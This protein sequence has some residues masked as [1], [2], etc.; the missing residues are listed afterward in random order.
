M[1]DLTGENELDLEAL[2]AKL[3]RMSDRDLLR[4]GRAARYMCSAF[5]NHGKAPR[6]EFEIQLLPTTP[7]IR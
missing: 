5:A 3:R 6:R 7:E 4:F 2:R 1:Y